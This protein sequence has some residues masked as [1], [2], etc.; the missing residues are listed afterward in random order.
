MTSVCGRSRTVGSGSI[1][2]PLLSERPETA[3]TAAAAASH[4]SHNQWRTRSLSSRSSILTRSREDGLASGVKPTMHYM[5]DGMPPAQLPAA[6]QYEWAVDQSARGWHET[7]RHSQRKSGRRLIPDR[8]SLIYRQSVANH[9]D[10]P[11]VATV[12]QS[13]NYNNLLLPQ[14]TWLPRQWLPKKCSVARPS[15]GW[16]SNRPVR[17]IPPARKELRNPRAMASLSSTMLTFNESE[18]GEPMLC[19]AERQ[20]S[21]IFE[22]GLPVI[23][24][25]RTGRQATLAK[26]GYAS[27]DSFQTSSRN[28]SLWTESGV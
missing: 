25:R 11:C 24:P 4:E 3:F 14:E 23:T 22:R 26:F 21:P 5:F 7:Q 2:M 18:E 6:V 15:T 9:V 28:M 20:S 17:A 13:L 12:A 10:S 1:A 16:S 27:F 19:D 8:Q